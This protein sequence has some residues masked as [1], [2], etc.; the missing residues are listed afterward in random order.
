MSRYK[1]KK[2]IAR[3]NKFQVSIYQIKEAALEPYIVC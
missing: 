3:Y 1:A 2:D